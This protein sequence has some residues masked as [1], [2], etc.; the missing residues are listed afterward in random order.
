MDAA[1]SELSATKAA[2]VTKCNGM[3]QICNRR[4]VREHKE[5]E[6]IRL[7][8]ARSRYKT[9]CNEN[10]TPPSSSSASSSSSISRFKTP[11]PPKND[12]TIFNN[13]Y[14]EIYK[15]RP[16]LKQLH[17]VPMLRGITLEIFLKCIQRRHAHIDLQRAITYVCDK[18][19]IQTDIKK[20]GAFLDTYLGIYEK[21]HM[22]NCQSRQQA[23]DLRAR[24]LKAFIEYSQ[25]M[26]GQYPER[27]EEMK[28]DMVRQYG[29]GFIQEA[30][31]LT[32]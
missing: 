26:A 15:S 31:K 19:E 12:A 18:A 28:R 29:Q 8:V 25:E 5:R 2:D 32:T 6:G 22:A 21:D 30:E 1:V 23:A 20:P 3:Y 24:D 16:L 14:E 9:P 10:V 17:A 4:M 11:L 7:R 13:E 27:V